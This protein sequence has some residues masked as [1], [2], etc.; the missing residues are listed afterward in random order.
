[1]QNGLYDNDAYKSDGKY[2]FRWIPYSTVANPQTMDR[3]SPDNETRYIEWTQ[4]SN[5]TIISTT[6]SGF[7]D[8][9][10][11]D[12]G[13]ESTEL[14]SGSANYFNGLYHR[15]ASW[16]GLITGSAG[17]PDCYALAKRASW[18]NN[19]ILFNIASTDYAGVQKTELYIWNNKT[20]ALTNTTPFSVSFEMNDPTNTGLTVKSGNV[21]VGS[22]NNVS[23]F[24]IFTFTTEQS[25]TDVETFYTNNLTTTT[26]TTTSVYANT[27]YRYIGQTVDL[28]T[29][30]VSLTDAYTG[31]G[32]ATET[33]TDTGDYFTYLVSVNDIGGVN[34]TLWKSLIDVDIL[35]NTTQLIST[36]NVP[37]V[38][39]D[40]T[41]SYISKTNTRTVT[42]GVELRSSGTVGYSQANHI[43]FKPFITLP[44]SFSVMVKSSISTGDSL[45]ILSVRYTTHELYNTFDTTSTIFA[46]VG[47]GMYPQ[48]T[49]HQAINTTSQTITGSP[50]GNGANKLWY[51]TYDEPTNTIT[52]YSG[53]STKVSSSVNVPSGTLMIYMNSWSFHKLKIQY[54]KA[55]S[56]SE[57][58]TIMA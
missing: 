35:Y 12:K 40:G 3:L 44:S 21:I 7:G 36:F 13:V 1:M 22:E 41:Y 5:P 17:D 51:I 48:Q 33:I 57:I 37:P 54:G 27:T 23:K 25:T 20:V 16:R 15:G 34:V 14:I 45:A 31:V 39:D 43:Y 29:L 18:R 56:L 32:T 58:E 52:T 30:G 49:T 50:P 2:L 8:L 6:V 28:A 11:L 47:Y 46:E 38:S 4:T 53:G 9:K 26:T 55:L 24:L 19:E 10:S 42:S